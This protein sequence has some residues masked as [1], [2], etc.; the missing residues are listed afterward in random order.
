MTTVSEQIDKWHADR[1]REQAIWC[2]HCGV[3]YEDE[4]FGCVSYHGSENGPTEVECANCDLP[5]HV[6]ETVR[7]TYETKKKDVMNVGETPS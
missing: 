7:R 6:H 1:R 5:F 4:D 3:E 2:P